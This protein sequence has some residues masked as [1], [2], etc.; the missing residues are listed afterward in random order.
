MFFRRITPQANDDSNDHF[1]LKKKSM[2]TILYSTTILFPTKE[3][4]QEKIKIL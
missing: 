4:E 3:E 2:A 1:S